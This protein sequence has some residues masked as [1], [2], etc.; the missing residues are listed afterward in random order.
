MFAFV[1]FV[2]GIFFVKCTWYERI[3]LILPM[4]ILFRP[5]LF[6]DLYQDWNINVW[7]VIGVALFFGIYAFQ[8][9]RSLNYNR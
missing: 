1:S 9:L 6:I 8:R 7:R 3:T 2:Q 5:D 4:L